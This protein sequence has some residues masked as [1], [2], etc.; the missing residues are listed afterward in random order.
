MTERRFKYA[1]TLSWI[2]GEY[3]QP[4]AEIDVVA[5]FSVSWGSPESG[6]WCGPP[7]D[8]NPGSDSVVEDVQII[9]IEGK[10]PAEYLKYADRPSEEIQTFIDKLEMDHD[11]AML[12][13]A[14]AIMGAEHD[15]AEERRYEARFERDR[16]WSDE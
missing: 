9:E 14:S 16:D 7:E 6:A 8:Y 11:E 2:G 4:D 12:E 10:P 5:S 1:T 3:N 13:V 15:D